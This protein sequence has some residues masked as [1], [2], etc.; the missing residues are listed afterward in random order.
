[1][2]YPGYAIAALMEYFAIFSRTKPKDAPKTI[3]DRIED[4]CGLIAFLAMT[5]TAIEEALA[6]KKGI[7]FARNAGLSEPL[8]KNMKKILTKAWMTYGGR[9]VL[10]GLA[11]G[12]S[13]LIM[14]KFTRPKKIENNS[15]LLF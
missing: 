9:A 10:G 2:R 13:R 14:D 1:M 3:T 8:I 4:N 7:E 11:V 12:A 5:P 15:A 6:S